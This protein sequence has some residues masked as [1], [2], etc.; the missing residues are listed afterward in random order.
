MIFLLSHQ[1]GAPDSGSGRLRFGIE[2]LG[3]L[4]VYAGL[5]ML[6]LVAFG[7]HH[8]RRRRRLWW[9]FVIVASYAVLDELHQT[10]VPGRSPTVTDVGIDM[11]GG[12]IGMV[13]A[14]RISRWAGDRS[15][16]R[17]SAR[18]IMGRQEGSSPH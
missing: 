9:T 16:P 12:L 11:V 15:A 14:D 7:Q 1:P 3:H 2:K 4:A 6:L 5:A 10:I 18:M 8:L 17:Q 13:V